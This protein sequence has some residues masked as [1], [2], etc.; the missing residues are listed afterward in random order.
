[1]GN[2]T[3]RPWPAVRAATL[4]MLSVFA[5][6]CAGEGIIE[7]TTTPAATESRPVL[8]TLTKAPDGTIIQSTPNPAA[9]LPPPFIDRRAGLWLVDLPSGRVH[10][11]HDV[12]IGA[13][14]EYWGSA[15]FAPDGTLWIE[16]FDDTRPLEHIGTD[17]TRL[18]LAPGERPPWSDVHCG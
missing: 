17:G 15:R 6:G 8:P 12:A 10:M 5:S 18:A 7:A 3:T 14:F 13:N 1:M 9:P 4:V 2:S 11:L 16:P